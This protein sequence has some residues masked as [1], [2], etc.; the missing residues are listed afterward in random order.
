MSDKLCIA[1]QLCFLTARVECR[2]KAGAVSSVGTGFF[3]SFPNDPNSNI[4]ALVTN[5]HVVEGSVTGSFN[6]TR[7]SADGTPDIG[8]YTEVLFGEFGSDWIVHPIGIWDRTNNMPVVRRGVAATRPD[9]DY[10][11]RK[12]FLIDAACFPGSSGAPVL[13]CNVGGYVTKFGATI[14]GTPRFK[15]LGVL[16][17]GPQYSVEGKMEIKTIPTKVTPVLSLNIPVNLGI[18]IKAEMIRGFTDVLRK[19]AQSG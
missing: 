1:D 2:D 15:L 10:E 6:M 4:P 19:A 11:G 14:V 12:E 17:S 16:Y 9:L 8:N 5:R 13:L 7:A 3:F 18:V